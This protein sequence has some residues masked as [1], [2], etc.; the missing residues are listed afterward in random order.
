MGTCYP[1]RCGTILKENMSEE[2]EAAIRSSLN[3]A[4]DAG[5][6]IL[7]NGGSSLDAVEASIIALEN[8]PWFNAGKGAVFNSEGGHELD[9]SIMDGKTLQAGAVA[10][11]TRVKNPI[12]AARKVMDHS[13]HVLLSGEGADEFASIMGLELVEPD[14]F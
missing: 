9:A 8:T 11:A 7:R 12:L 13:E 4:L 14:Y 1:W 6:E 3:E 10:G 5:G 2:K